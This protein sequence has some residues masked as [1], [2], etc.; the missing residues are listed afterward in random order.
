MFFPFC[1]KLSVFNFVVLHNTILWYLYTTV[2]VYNFPSVFYYTIWMPHTLSTRK[3]VYRHNKKRH[4]TAQTVY[5]YLPFNRIQQN[6]YNTFPVLFT[7]RLFWK[8]F[9]SELQWI[10]LFNTNDILTSITIYVVL[11]ILRYTLV[12][13]PRQIYNTF[14]SL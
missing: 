5:Y 6:K 9:V 13:F 8:R 12:N 2:F 14:V 7:I 10:F 3:Y 11:V 1:L 4:V